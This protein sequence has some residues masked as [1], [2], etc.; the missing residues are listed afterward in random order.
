MIQDS[1]LASSNRNPHLSLSFSV[2]NQL[3]GA[4]AGPSNVI[5]YRHFC[6]SI[7]DTSNFTRGLDS[8]G[9]PVHYVTL[10]ALSNT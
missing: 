7:E 8:D 4:G 1:C 10:M 6:S 3:T 9:E 2:F 5:S